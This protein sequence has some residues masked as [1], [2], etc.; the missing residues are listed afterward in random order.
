MSMGLGPSFDRAQRAY[1]AQM[2]PE[3]P[4]PIQ[5]ECR[6]CGEPFETDDPEETYCDECHDKE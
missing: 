5:K 1:D 4:P 3:D 2:P 6:Q